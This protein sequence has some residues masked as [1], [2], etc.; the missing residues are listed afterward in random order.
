MATLKVTIVGRYEAAP[1]NYEPGATPPQMAA[2]DQEDI[3]NGA[4]D[5]HDAL[6]W[7]G[8]RD[9]TVRIEADS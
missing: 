7:C 2:Q 5:E 1:E 3:D 8:G 4:V 6:F 9:I